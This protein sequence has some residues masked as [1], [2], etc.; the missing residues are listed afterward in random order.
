MVVTL[1]KPHYEAEPG[2]L[3]R[4]V[5]PEELVETVVNEVKPAILA[6]GFSVKGM[7]RSPIVGAK[8]NVEMLA[9]LVPLA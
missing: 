8:G 4:G 9:W 5:L 6:A 2:C 3:R 7:V 1:I